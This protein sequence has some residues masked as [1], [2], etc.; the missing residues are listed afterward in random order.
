MRLEGGRFG[1][2][3]VR[4]PIPPTNSRSQIH[5]HPGARRR[6][7]ASR[8]LPRLRTFS[9]SLGVGAIPEEV[10]L[11]YDDPLSSAQKLLEALGQT[12]AAGVI[13][14]ASRQMD[15]PP[16]EGLHPVLEHWAV[17]DGE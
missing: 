4:L 16:V 3:D 1:A 11:I 9:F 10:R 14:F 2:F 15:D 17:V 5:A 12:I 6:R 7:R 13:Q 8:T